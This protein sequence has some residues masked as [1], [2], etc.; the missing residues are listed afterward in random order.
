MVQLVLV[1]DIGEQ[2]TVFELIGRVSS[3]GAHLSWPKCCITS[4]LTSATQH[5]GDNWP[6]VSDLGM[7]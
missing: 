3:V 5:I 2:E 7:S 6:R 1:V 4:S